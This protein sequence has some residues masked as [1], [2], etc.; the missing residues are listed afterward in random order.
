LQENGD[1]KILTQLSVKISLLKQL[2]I[3]SKTKEYT[4]P[5]FFPELEAWVK[6]Q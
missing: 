5:T 6:L 2:K 3:Q 4:M 1:Q